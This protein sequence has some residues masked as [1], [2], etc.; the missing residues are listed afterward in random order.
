MCCHLLEC[1]IQ[2]VIDDV[3]RGLY[4]ILLLYIHEKHMITLYPLVGT[5]LDANSLRRVLHI[6]QKY[7]E[8]V[9]MNG[10]INHGHV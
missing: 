7:I 1:S 3:C 5:V 6:E 8:P 9:S 4:V 2:S 10:I